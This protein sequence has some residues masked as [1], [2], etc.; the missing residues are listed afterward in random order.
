MAVLETTL[1]TVP[2]TE[3]DAQTQTRLPLTQIIAGASLVRQASWYQLRN[4]LDPVAWY[5]V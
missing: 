3:A 1:E 5:G 4:V 2:Q